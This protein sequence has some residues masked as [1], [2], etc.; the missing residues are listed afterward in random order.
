[1]KTIK[2]QSVS[3]GNRNP[4]ELPGQVKLNEKII[5]A[6]KYF[7]NTSEDDLEYV[8]GEKTFSFFFYKLLNPQI[9]NSFLMNDD[10]QKNLEKLIIRVDGKDVSFEILNPLYKRISDTNSTDFVEIYTLILVNF[11]N[12]CQS[13]DLDQIKIKGSKRDES[14][15]FTKKHENKKEIF[16]ENYLDEFIKNNATIH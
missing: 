2:P 16:Q 5:E 1:M 11:L 9:Q 7:L 14:Y 13:V 15:I 12:F 4:S 10:F 6:I 8:F 3:V